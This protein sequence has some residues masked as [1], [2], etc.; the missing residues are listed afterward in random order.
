MNAPLSPPTREAVSPEVLKI[1]LG[2]LMAMFLAALDQT[3]VA[4]ALPTL[5]RD[6][7]DLDHLPWV[8]TA[9]LLASTAVAP[10]YGKLSDIY[11]RRVMMLTGIWIFLAGSVACALAPTMLALV[12]ARAL[13]GLGGGGLISLAQTIIADVVPPRDRPRYQVHI[14]SVFVAS[15][16]AGPVLGGVF[17]E[18]L[19]W[20][21]IFWI[22]V[23]VGL[24]ALAMTSARLKLLPRHERYHRLDLLG[25]L[26]MVCA[27]T[28]LM[29]ALT[30][31][32]VS[33][34]WLS[35]QVVGLLLGSALLW[36]AFTWRLLTAAEPFLPLNLFSNSV[37][38]W[39]TLGSCFTM[40][41]FIGL[42]IYAPIYLQSVLGMSAAD[43]GFALIPL[44]AGTV[45]GAVLSGRNMARLKH[46]KRLP[47]AGLALS[48][49]TMAALT[50]Y[51][52][53]LPLWL[54]EVLFGLASFGLGTVLPVVTVSIQNA[55]PLHQL[56]TAT[57]NMN[58]FR[59]L[60]GAIAVAAFGAILFGGLSA[61]GDDLRSLD[62][63][64]REA[65]REVLAGVF[66]WV[67]FASGVGIGLAL[68]SLAL[69]KELPL[70]ASIAHA[71]DSVGE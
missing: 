7:G 36:I 45:S 34:P 71:A 48:I 10:L 18:H 5:G 70:R 32:G 26:L 8:V 33:Y 50:V 3:I 11:G 56:G 66:R 12:L 15:S 59:S 46:Y 4:T 35:V 23:P 68:L 47:M 44:M 40:G 65:N 16:V 9:Y 31:G 61:G 1:I 29:L 43:S 52:I 22:N 30:W 38:L 19:H 24:V 64:V 55:V 39:A 14:A 28:T 6:L 67:Y 60:G 42:T 41:T 51:P 17:A 58:F 37:V 54:L 62:D 63:L 25:A 49:G 69:M 13:Q 27:S 2:I 21:L 53:G 57:A 20:S